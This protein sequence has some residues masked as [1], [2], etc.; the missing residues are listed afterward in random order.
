[1][2]EPEMDGV[3]GEGREVLVANH[4]DAPFHDGKKD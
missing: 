4:T 2:H 3:M 1:M